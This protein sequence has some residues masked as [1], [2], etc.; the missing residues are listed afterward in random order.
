M[1]CHR[2]GLMINYIH[3][4]EITAIMM[5][6]EDNMK[7]L[8]AYPRK[9]QRNIQ[10]GKW[11]LVKCN[12]SFIF[13]T[14]LIIN[15]NHLFTM[16]LFLIL[17]GAQYNGKDHTVGLQFQSYIGGHYGAL[18]LG[19]GLFTGSYIYTNLNYA[20]EMRKCDTPLHTFPEA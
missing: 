15:F 16:T 18:L 14:S 19:S 13:P 4:K 8:H 3:I 20:N 11:A 1:K 5:M 10:E 9:E 12:S 17:V 6:S 7:R 2:L